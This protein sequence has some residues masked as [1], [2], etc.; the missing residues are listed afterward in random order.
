M[1]VPPSSGSYGAAGTSSRDDVPKKPRS[2]VGQLFGSSASVPVV[3]G[4]GVLCMVV[5]AAVG[6][7]ASPSLA[8]GW[9]GAG[10]IGV[11]PVAMA[12]AREGIARDVHAAPRVVAPPLE[13]A[14]A[15]S[16][17]EEKAR[18]ETT[19]ENLN[20]RL[21]SLGDAR[22]ED[23]SDSDVVETPDTKVFPA[24]G[25]TP[26]ANAETTRAAR[27][28][29]RVAER[30]E[31]RLHD[32]LERQVDSQLGAAAT[33]GAGA[34][35]RPGPKRVPSFP[36][37]P[38][39]APNH[40]VPGQ[41]AN[42][43]DNVETD[44]TASTTAE[45]EAT[46]N[47][48]G[49]KTGKK[50][51]SSKPDKKGTD[52]TTE[53]G[54]DAES[55]AD[56]AYGA[57]DDAYGGGGS[58]VDMINSM[59]EGAMD[60]RTEIHAPP[61]ELSAKNTEL[62]KHLDRSIPDMA[63]EKEMGYF[64]YP[65]L[66]GDAL[67]FVSE[68]NVWYA[69][70]SGGAAAR[71]SASY[72]VEALPKLNK[73]GTVIAFLAQSVDGYEVFTL[74]VAGG[75]AKRV[76]YGSAAVK[77]E[78][79][80]AD[81][82][83]LVVTSFFSPTGLAQLATVDPDT[84]EMTVLP[85][86]RASG[87]TQDATD[88][89]YVFYP[90]RQTSATKR[91]EGGE[92]SRLWR[93]CDGDDEATLLT[94]ESW[95][96]R[97]AWS[98][99]TSPAFPDQIFFISDHSG[100][101]NVWVMDKDGTN[102]RQL[103]NSCGMDVMEMTIDGKDGIARI[104][105]GLHKFAIDDAPA[106][107][108]KGLVGAILT[109]A[110]HEIPITLTSEFRDAAEQKIF[111]PLEELRELALSQDGFYAALVIR[112]QIFFT[113]LLEQLGTRLEQVTQ[114]QG[115][116]RYRHV[117][118]VKSDSP[119]DNT[120]IIAMSDAS[121]EYE[122]V[123][124]ERQKGGKMGAAWTETQ[125]TKGGKIRGVMSYSD[126]SPDGTALVFDDTY[127]EVNVLNLTS[128][129][130]NTAK[131]RTDSGP[132]A[133]EQ[134]SM[135]E[136]MINQLM[137]AAGGMAGGGGG[138]DATAQSR[139]MAMKKGKGGNKPNVVNP[140][141]DDEDVDVDDEDV[142]DAQ[143]Q[144]PKAPAGGKDTDAARE[145][146]RLR[147][148]RRAGLRR[149]ARSQF[150]R[151]WRVAA[152]LGTESKGGFT[153][154]GFD[155]GFDQGARAR[156]MHHS[157]Y[158]QMPSE[159]GY[160]SLFGAHLGAAPPPRPSGSGGGG[161][162]KSGQANMRTVMSGLRP[163]A[164]GDYSWS[165]DG[166]W[167]AFSASDA[168]EF[169]CVHVWN[170]ETGETQRLTHP[171]YNAVEPKFSP[172]GFFLYY[173]SD[174]QIESEA[175]SPY[176]ARGGEPSYLGTQQLMCLPLREGFKC[177][178]FMGDELNVAGQIFDPAVGKQIATKI[179]MN[180]IEKRAVPV[181][182]L[183][184][185]QYFGLHIIGQGNTFIM[186]M[187]DGVGFYL[188]AMDIISGTV[189]PIY[190]DPIGV[191]VSGDS[192][193]VMIAVEQGLALFSSE[194][195]ATPG[196]AQDQLLASA[197]VWAPPESWAVTISP[198]AEWMQMYN[199]AMRNMRD[200]FYD[201][202]MHGLDWEGITEMYR[203]LVY[204]VSTKSDL[205]DVLQ[206][207][208]GELSV[209]HVFVSIRSDA[210]TLPVGEPSACLGGNLRKTERGMEVVRVF[211]TSGILGAPDSPLSAMAV[212]LRPGDVITRVDGVPLNDTGALVS[213]S[214]LGKSGMQV[215]L[216][217]DVKPRDPPDAEEQMILDQLQMGAAGGG[218]AGGQGGAAGG[219]S[220]QGAMGA[221]SY[222]GGYGQGGYGGYGGQGGYGQGNPHQQSAPQWMT[223][224]GHGHG[225]G[226][227]TVTH[228]VKEV[229]RM[230]ALG[231]AAKGATKPSLPSKPGAAQA[232]AAPGAAAPKLTPKRDGGNA[233]EVPEEEKKIG[234]IQ[235]FVVT[236]L[237]HFEC[238]TLRAADALN[239][240]KN[241][242]TSRSNGDISYIY[243]EDM[244]QMGQGESNS[245]DDFAA[246]FYPAIRKA[247]LIIDVRRNAGGNI[248]TWI[249]ERLRRVAW[250]FNTERSG[251]GDT[252]MQYAFMGKVAVLVD[253]MTSSDAEI[254]AAGIQRL[255]LGK[256]IGMRSWGGAVGYS[257]NPELSLVDGSGF[258]IPSF[259][260]YA[261]DRWMIEQQGVVP[262]IVVDNPPVAAFNGHDAQLDA[263]IDHL[264]DEIAEVKGDEV[265]P[266]KPAYPDWSFDRDVCKS[267]GDGS[268]RSRDVRALVMGA[269]E[270][271]PAAEEVKKLTPKKAKK[272]HHKHHKHGEDSA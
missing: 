125:L 90:L 165:P 16:I 80:T 157:R 242:V 93:W 230:A 252:T 126:V 236:P 133:E 251:P 105:G 184:K 246:Q 54:T 33:P 17:R 79:W 187:W 53:G 97:G 27:V 129:A 14:S 136:M 177:P 203:P 30:K 169:S 163:E 216:E 131:Y 175:G 9:G 215:L 8:T 199:D 18:L 261:G 58:M 227:Q 194:A 118:F 219:A 231:A 26:D 200:A 137:G 206:Q 69:K 248:D 167:L 185:K 209:L 159:G 217:V 171:S 268:K 254:F 21:A 189:L 247:G 241:H 3:I 158:G 63:G 11:A 12:T 51:P 144:K 15:S 109:E 174:Q 23:D 98:P 59:I 147:R 100:V 232:A 204:R 1:F 45:D 101:A 28:A 213:R 196:V 192:S 208:L 211:D 193:V 239:A 102:K 84:S 205:R 111:A 154:S 99:V 41:G 190:P 48:G 178:F 5:G 67:V 146:S 89:C 2:V 31:A 250:M 212:D 52:E 120:K 65:H 225:H 260:P 162:K 66:R 202:N 81:G 173:F 259:G 253:E 240:R 106:G 6:V 92:Q 237:S 198:R 91:Y 110:P 181:P 214:L 140:S 135:Q 149:E 19:E 34:L 152:N 220:G 270:P 61:A 104:G 272:S 95:S 55:Y 38:S 128:T 150:R 77:L 265:I 47:D 87:G 37:D 76:S 161:K 179:A 127:G 43:D 86:A 121:G 197:V 75:V 191:Y 224:G 271:L 182:F 78:G 234:G 155:G 112:G 138:A 267:G 88:G 164:A 183:E 44:S 32:R 228:K 210:P 113:P 20:I 180:N 221:G 24:L 39:D 245:F 85:F 50:D 160:S 130:V 262:D 263:A 148:K 35:P 94:P 188:V 4:I 22:D 153:F 96:K 170:V 82:K 195:I 83:I 10:G 103:T 238:S 143:G 124:L 172:D 186:Q 71:V 40:P 256:V 207:A 156:D 233:T 249:L 255:G 176:G 218:G 223:R 151:D 235:N 116:V 222:G 108:E 46:K 117:Q 64:R 62:L 142:D 57:Y 226:L 141:D 60:S 72:S 70:K 119:G 269:P 49:K 42:G 115:A 107:N 244:E 168:S 243:L 139:R 114:H 132:T 258:T 13:R 74:P 201:P 7:L 166:K 134:A 56:A 264:L 266:E 257:S 73:N 68:G 36:A 229:R 29:E 145:R 25:A 123:L 122:Y